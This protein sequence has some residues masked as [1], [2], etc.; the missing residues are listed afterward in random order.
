M[1]RRTRGDIGCVWSEYACEIK[2]GSQR[3]PV[4]GSSRG[5]NG[6]VGS[7]EGWRSDNET[8]FTTIDDHAFAQDLTR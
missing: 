1:T 2:R 8:D 4:P 6:N 3:M 5:E 7:V